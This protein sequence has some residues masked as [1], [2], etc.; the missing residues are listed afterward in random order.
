MDLSQA[1]AENAKQMKRLEA[2]I[3][4]LK[5]QRPDNSFKTIL[6][7]GIPKGASEDEVVQQLAPMAPA[8]G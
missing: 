2:T 1:S 3:A 5:R 8:L 6:F 4:K 7:L